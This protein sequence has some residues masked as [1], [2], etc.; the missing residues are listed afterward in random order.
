MDKDKFDAKDRV[1]ELSPK[2]MQT[3]DSI[4]SNPQFFIDTYNTLTW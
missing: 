2:E 1:E 4:M 3:I